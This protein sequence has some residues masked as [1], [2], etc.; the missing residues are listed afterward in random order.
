MR[1]PDAAD[2]PVSVAHPDELVPAPPRDAFLA[3]LPVD[4]E[5]ADP[6][7]Q[8]SA[9]P[10]LAVRPPDAVLPALQVLRLQRGLLPLAAALTVPPRVEARLSEL[11]PVVL[12]PPVALDASDEFLA[13]RLPVQ[14]VAHLPVALQAVPP[15]DAAEL[16]AVA[17]S[18]PAQQ[19]AEALPL[20]RE[21]LAV[22]VQR[23]LPLPEAQCAQQLRA[24]AP[25]LVPPVSRQARARRR[26]AARFSLSP[27]RSSP[28]QR[29]PRLLRA[30]G[31]ASAP[32]PRARCQSSSSAS[33]F[34]Q[35]RSSAKSRSAPWP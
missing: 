26:D 16:P 11:L 28:P 7:E 24:L 35:R 8:G 22:P 27:R 12:V 2:L 6:V 23:E 21:L 20:L 14:R 19:V 13:V 15:R 3:A 34:P 4:S 1:R 31:N 29:Q 25:Q 18:L 33:F 5:T 30:L 10:V 17:R 32:T 9:V